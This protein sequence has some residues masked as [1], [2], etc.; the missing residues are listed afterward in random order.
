MQQ[1]FKLFYLTQLL[2]NVFEKCYRFFTLNMFYL[3]FYCHVCLT[4]Y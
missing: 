3:D 1:F 2:K 4:F